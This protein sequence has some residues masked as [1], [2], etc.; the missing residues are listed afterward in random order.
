MLGPARTA[1]GE[2]AWVTADQVGAVAVAASLA[3]ESG[4]QLHLG[5]RAEADAV[6]GSLEP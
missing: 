1:V 2:D 5:D 3:A 4:G 6:L